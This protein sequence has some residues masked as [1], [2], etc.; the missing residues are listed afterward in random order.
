MFSP[1]DYP[2]IVSGK[3]ILMIDPQ[4]KNPDRI[5]QFFP[6]S[7][8]KKNRWK[9]FSRDCLEAFKNTFNFNE[10]T[11]K[12]GH[13]SGAMFWFPLRLKPS[14]LSDNICTPRQVEQLFLAFIDESKWS[15]LFLK[16]VCKVEMFVNLGEANNV[17]DTTQSPKRKRLKLSRS[18][19]R[20]D[21]PSQLERMAQGKDEPSYCVFI[22]TEKGDIEVQRMNFLKTIPN[23]LRDGVPKNS[24]VWGANVVVT[25]KLCDEMTMETNWYVLNYMKGE[26]VSPRMEELIR[27]DELCSLHLVGLAAP[28]LK[29][30]Q[31]T[32][33][34]GHVFCYLP[35]PRDDSNV[36]GLPVHVNAFFSLSQNRRHIKWPDN[37][38]QVDMEKEMEWNLGLAR[39]IL[40]EAYVNLVQHLVECAKK[41]DNRSIIQA[42]YFAFPDLNAVDGRWQEL[43]KETIKLLGSREILLAADSTWQSPMKSIFAHQRMYPK[44]SPNCWNTVKS[45]AETQLPNLV[46]TEK[47]VVESLE[48]LFKGNL[49][50]LTPAILHD[51]LIQNSA[52]TKLSSDKKIHLLEF[53]TSD[54]TYDHLDQ[55]ELLPLANKMF[56]RFLR[57]DAED[58]FLEESEIVDLFPRQLESFVATDLDR[59]CMALLKS[60]TKSGKW[61][62]YNLVSILVF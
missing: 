47:H 21:I 25:T 38:E 7:K 61:F 59:N 11:F 58:V 29:V 5:C 41:E 9:S 27:D 31:Y 2:C 16:T 32:H 54:K 17:P 49:N 1:T 22:N 24:L 20:E 36:T 44:L 6:L 30:G 13:Y 37:N 45:L 10:K 3:R 40:P 56:T 12:T 15:L 19:N 55:L 60:I 53:L 26:G 35:L 8:H 42:V 43:A 34:K 48:K 23:I 50:Y 52:Y 51:Q 57:K 39:E 18:Q 62:V 14:E 33:D 4:E 46:T 28:I